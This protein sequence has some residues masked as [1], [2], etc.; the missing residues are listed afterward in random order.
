MSLNYLSLF[1]LLSPTQNL[2]LR[3]CLSW[4]PTNLPNKNHHQSNGIPKWQSNQLIKGRLFK[5]LPFVSLSLADYSVFN[6]LSDPLPVRFEHKQFLPC[7]IN[8]MPSSIQLK[9]RAA[10]GTP[11]EI[12]HAGHSFH[13]T[14][15]A[16]VHHNKI[17]ASPLIFS[18]RQPSKLPY[19]PT[20]DSQWF[21]AHLKDIPQAI[22]IR[23][24]VDLY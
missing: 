16:S 22:S 24:H 21:K 9:T 1:H 17:P 6:N 19:L 3:N 4:F 2:V 11:S 13:K 7:S 20:C 10:T 8:Y 5:T 14:R 23:L 12:W 18:K 15:N